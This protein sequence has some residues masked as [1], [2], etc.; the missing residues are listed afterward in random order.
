MRPT[1][2]AGLLSLGFPFP[3]RVLVIIFSAAVFLSPA[4]KPP[5]KRC[6]DPSTSLQSDLVPYGGLLDVTEAM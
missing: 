1:A 3:D 2:A 4:D 6:G 5:V